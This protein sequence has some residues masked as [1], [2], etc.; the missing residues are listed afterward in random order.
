MYERIPK[1]TETLAS[2][3]VKGALAGAVGVWAMDQVG[4]AMYN[5]EDPA[6]L[7]Q[8]LEA[9]VEGKDPA[10]VAAGKMADMVGVTLTPEQ[11]HPAGIGV[12]YALGVVP[13]AAYGV[14]RHRV[15]E[16]TAGR[17]LLYGLG[18]FLVQDEGLAPA[19]GLASGPTQYPWQAHARGLISHL[20]LGAVTDAVLNILDEVQISAADE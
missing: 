6:A 13:G 7:E 4:W 2:E 17:G 14:L 16:L 11:P 5:R 3:M 8:E 19:L 12:H 9:R 18:L 20:V 10:H 15:P 1:E